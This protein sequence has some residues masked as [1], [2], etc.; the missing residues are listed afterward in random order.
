MKRL[1]TIIALCTSLVAAGEAAAATSLIAAYDHYVSGQGFEIG[2]VDVG[3]GDGIA[4]PAGVNT[5]QDEIHPGLTAD[6]RYLVF[7][8]MQLQPLL[9]GDVVP[10]S[11]RT[12][13][14][15]DRTTGEA[16]DP[17][18]GENLAGAGATITPGPV[19][20]DRLAF[21][22]RPSSSRSASAPAR[23]VT[24]G[25]RGP[26][27]FIQ[28]DS[29][30]LTS[31]GPVEGESASSV[32]DIPAAT[33]IRRPDKLLHGYTLLRFDPGTGQ[34]QDTRVVIEPG[35][36]P[37]P[38]ASSVT[39][40]SAG[41]PA[42]RDPDGY[43]A[44][45]SSSGATG[46]A[47]SDIRTLLFPAQAQSS[48]APSPIN[49]GGDER[50]SAWGPDGLKLAFVRRVSDPPSLPLSNERLLLVF[51][52]TPG[53]QTIQNP[54]LDLGVPAPTPQLRAFHDA[55]GG[56]ALAVETRP[57]AAK[58]SCTLRCFGSLNG[59]R[60]GALRPVNLS[61][62]VSATK[63]SGP[64][65]P[66]AGGSGVGILVAKVVGKHRVLG[67]RV[68]RLKPLG[69]V[70]L[71]RARR[72]RNRFRWN[73]RVAGRRLR[74]GSYVIT[75]RVLTRGGRIQATSRTIQ[76]RVT[77]SRRIARARLLR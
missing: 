19:G 14:M 42:L 51:D 65:G 58:V 38:S 33:F 37:S 45:E 63:P 26:R 44:F 36:S 43:A 35:P 46:G 29:D 9:N 59:A 6:G 12:L 7:T 30:H 47:N 39:F 61:P 64:I 56:V 48:N 74:P 18:T 49:T 34:A 21:G 54:A 55:W 75:Y 73:G 41:H 11:S 15:V 4:V 77:R 53:I 20:T 22:V 72:G 5:T 1:L 24:G 25:R 67:R 17:M 66:G 16:V 69:R 13:M 32:L 50:M 3:T 52:L 31:T 60:L 71:G 68:P 28:F 70:P 62:T 23:I 27:N 8:R 2:L 40:Q 10:P 76:F 57:D